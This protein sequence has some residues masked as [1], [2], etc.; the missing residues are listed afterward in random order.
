MI[1]Q[2]SRYFLSQLSGPFRRTT[3]DSV[4][5]SVS[6]PNPSTNELVPL[7]EGEGRNKPNTNKKAQRIFPS[8]NVAESDAE[9]VRISARKR[10]TTTSLLENSAAADFASATGEKRIKNAKKRKGTYGRYTHT[11]TDG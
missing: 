7:T 5:Q 1:P 9:I 11:R 8:T 3:P 2:L 10:T 6:T 4:S